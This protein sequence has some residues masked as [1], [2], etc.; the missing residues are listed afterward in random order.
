MGRRERIFTLKLKE[1]NVL[2]S[3]HTNGHRPTNGELWQGDGRVPVAGVTTY[4]GRVD[5]VITFFVDQFLSDDIFMPGDLLELASEQGESLVL[6]TRHG[7]SAD[8][9]AGH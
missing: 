1:E 6:V 3:V 4:R 5:A 8:D 7:N 2:Q 9:L